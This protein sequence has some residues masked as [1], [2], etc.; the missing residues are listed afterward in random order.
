MIVR[1]LVRAR[2]F[3]RNVNYI[4]L[5]IGSIEMV[6]WAKIAQ[7]SGYPKHEFER[8][9]NFKWVIGSC[10]YAQIKCIGVYKRCSV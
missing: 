2:T 7:N 8:A 1:S 5:V 6:N 4:Y 3:K 10:L 9:R